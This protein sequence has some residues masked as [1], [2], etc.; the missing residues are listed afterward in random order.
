MAGYFYQ[1][2]QSS[3]DA[4]AGVAALVDVAGRKVSLVLAQLAQ[5]D[6]GWAEADPGTGQ[7][8]SGSI[9]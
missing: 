7:R 5:L 8:T 9:G 4:A 6:S 1:P 2:P 3:S